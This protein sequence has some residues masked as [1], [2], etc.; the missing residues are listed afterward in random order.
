MIH[1]GFEPPTYFCWQRRLFLPPIIFQYAPYQ[2][3]NHFTNTT[4]MTPNPR[5]ALSNTVK[6]PH[7][8][9]P[10]TTT[11][12]GAL[13]TG[14]SFSLTD[15]DEAMLQELDSYPQRS[16]KTTL[17][18]GPIS[19]QQYWMGSSLWQQINWNTLVEGYEDQLTMHKTTGIIGFTVLFF[20]SIQSHQ[21]TGTHRLDCPCASERPWW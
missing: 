2:I 18:I 5:F 6:L 15:S 1:P 21:T 4:C 20:L 17:T 10:L 19:G 13:V 16:I 14:W 7:A 8:V 12:L 3:A 9:S 11:I